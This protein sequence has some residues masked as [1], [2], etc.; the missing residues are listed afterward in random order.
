MSPT[1]FPRCTAPLYR[2]WHTHWGATPDEITSELPGDT[3][4]PHAQFRSTRAI[5]IDAPPEAVWPWLVQVGCLRAGFYSNDLLDNLAYPS[6]TT[7]RPDLQHLEVGQWVP[8]SPTPPPTE[9]TAFKVHSFDT[10]SWLLWTKPDGTWSWRLT[11]S[12]TNTTRLVTRVHAVYDWHH[13]LSA[14][15]GAVLMEFGDFAMQRRMLR[16]IKLR[17]EALT[18]PQ[19]RHHRGPP[20]AVPG[21]NTPT[22]PGVYLYWIPLGAGARVVRS[23]GRFFETLSA[24]AQRRPRRDLYHSALV[25]VTAD[26]PFSVE[27]TPIPGPRGPEIAAWSPKAPLA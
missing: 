15:F 24:L 25:A 14:L 8:M 10:N 1:T 3:L 5:T 22:A 2:T 9:R 12:D 20:Q 17:A 6:A 4:L 27:M 23:S 26:A 21:A 11:R 19:S 7:I 16:G 18:S 13:P